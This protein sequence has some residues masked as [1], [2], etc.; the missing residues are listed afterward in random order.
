[1][2][3]K[4]VEDLKKKLDKVACE[5]RHVPHLPVLLLLDVSASMKGGAIEELNRIV[6]QFRDEV[7]EIPEARNR[8]DIAIMA[9]ND[10]P[11][12]EPFYSIDA[13]EPTE[14]VAQGCTNT[15]EAMIHAARYLSDYNAAL[16]REGVDM[17]RPIIV[18][19]TDG[20]S[21]STEYDT[22]EAVALIRSKMNKDEV[23]GTNRLKLWN[24]LVT[25]S[26]S[27]NEISRGERECLQA[28]R[29][30][31]PFT[32]LAKNR[33]Y[34]AIFDWLSDSF[35]VIISSQLEFDENGNAFEIDM[36]SPQMQTDL[37][38]MFNM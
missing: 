20:I 18:H 7:M 28:L 23:T 36:E 19:I 24:F 31:S 9:Y 8:I 13:W 17:Y 35:K 5:R 14:L 4:Y 22:R 15:A 30:Y 32:V 12:V 10:V 29:Q 33:N 11:K 6:R 3:E 21:T 16:N 1:M 2:V 26:S 38:T 37:T 25:E 27:V 34:S